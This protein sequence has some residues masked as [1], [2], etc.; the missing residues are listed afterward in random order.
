MHC[1][2]S[3]AGRLNNSIDRLENYNSIDRLEANN[4][5]DRL[6][7]YNSIDRLEDYITVTTGWKP[8]PQELRVMRLGKAKSRSENTAALAN[9]RS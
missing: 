4:S 9:F 2:P 8:I 7:D 3:Q 1:Y 5:I 6:E